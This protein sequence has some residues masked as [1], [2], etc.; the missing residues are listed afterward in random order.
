LPDFY[1]SDE[2]L[3]DKDIFDEERDNNLESKV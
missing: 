3:D 1:E 2:E